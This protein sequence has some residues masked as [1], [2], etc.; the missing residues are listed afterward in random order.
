MLY[1]SGEKDENNVS[2]EELFFL[3]N[4]QVVNKVKLPGHCPRQPAVD[5]PAPVGTFQR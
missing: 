2:N 3:K 5:I 4:Y 1:L